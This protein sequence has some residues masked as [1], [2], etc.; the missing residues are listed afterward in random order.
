[1]IMA[2]KIEVGFDWIFNFRQSCIADGNRSGIAL[3]SASER[4][5]RRSRLRSN[6]FESLHIPAN[7]NDVL[8][9]MLESALWSL[10]VTP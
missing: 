6:T 9:C 8:C 7:R 1:M 2:R 5:S 3:S 10:T 4:R